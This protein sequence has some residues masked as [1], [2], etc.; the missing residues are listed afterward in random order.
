M[1]KQQKTKGEKQIAKSTSKKKDQKQDKKE[2]EV[3]EN[4][5]KVKSPTIK[6]RPSSV[7]KMSPKVVQIKVLPPNLPNKLHQQKRRN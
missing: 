2:E 1:P 6:N 3:V 5:P 7:K 4:P